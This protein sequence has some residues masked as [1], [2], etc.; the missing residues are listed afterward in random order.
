VVGARGYS[1][2][3]IMMFFLL[4]QLAVAKDSCAAQAAACIASG[5]VG[6]R[7][8]AQLAARGG[9]TGRCVQCQRCRGGACIGRSPLVDAGGYFWWG[10]MYAW[11]LSCFSLHAVPHARRAPGIMYALL[12]A[13]LAARTVR[14]KPTVVPSTHP[15]ALPH[16][17]PPQHAPPPAPW[18]YLT[19][20]CVH[21]ML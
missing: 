14:R 19:C 18:H 6:G 15:V 9:D 1:W 12:P 7:R 13:Q 17:Q 16:S 2:W 8:R 20:N 5:A 3:G 4:L 11:C 10:I 21:C